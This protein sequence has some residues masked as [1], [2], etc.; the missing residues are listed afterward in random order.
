MNGHTQSV[1]E[2]RVEVRFPG[3]EWGT[4]C[5]DHFDLRDANVVCR[6]L[7]HTVADRMFSPAYEYGV[8]SDDVNT[9]L[10]NLKCRGDENSLM[11]CR[12]RGWGISNCGHF[13]DVGVVCKNDS[14]P[15][16]NG[17]L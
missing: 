4:I 6:M 1:L 14:I 7:N 9:W 5:D 8:V 16:L 12:H 2:G 15:T 13:E 11:E 3:G 17:K 10:D